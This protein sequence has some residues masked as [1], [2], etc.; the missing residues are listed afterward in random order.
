MT[1][2][3]PS[4]INSHGRRLVADG[5]ATLFMA[6]GEQTPDD[7]AGAGTQPDQDLWPPED[8]KRIVDSLADGVLVIGTAAA[9]L[10]LNPAA[11]AMLRRSSSDLIGHSLNRILPPDESHWAELVAAAVEGTS[12]EVVG[13]RQELNL[14][15]GHG[16]RVPV[17]LVV[18]VGM[19]RMGWPVAIAVIRSGERSAAP[20]PH[21]L[22]R[23][24]A[25]GAQRFLEL[26]ACRAAAGVTLSPARLG[27]RRSLGA[28]A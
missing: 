4:R 27:R 19:T 17:E 7:P 21:R 10:Y 23:T 22:H 14:L 1:R 26:I 8:V 2:L 20:S 5:M 11:S 28:P 6:E 12:T 3:L 9:I 15:D 25:R 18:S 24:T 16:R 13:S